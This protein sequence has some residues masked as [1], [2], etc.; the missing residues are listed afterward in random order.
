MQVGRGIDGH[1]EFKED[2]IHVAGAEDAKLLRTVDWLARLYEFLRLAVG[3]HDGR[4]SDGFFLPVEE[5]FVALGG[6]SVFQPLE[7]A[8]LMSCHRAELLPEFP[9]LFGVLL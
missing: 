8:E 3:L 7:C 1:A 5:Y 4:A 9:F 2:W 6:E